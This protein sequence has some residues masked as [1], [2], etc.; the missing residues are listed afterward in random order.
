MVPLA[1]QF[2]SVAEAKT[3]ED[4]V[5]TLSLCARHRTALRTRDE[6]LKSSQRSKPMR[7][8]DS[9]FIDM[10]RLV[11]LEIIHLSH[12]LGQHQPRFRCFKSLR[13]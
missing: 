12:P 11:A 7:N 5:V 8:P 3:E 6:S 10:N 9:E 13:H 2:M 4:E 1:T